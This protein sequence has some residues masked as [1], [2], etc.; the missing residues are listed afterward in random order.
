MPGP[1]PKALI[2]RALAIEPSQKTL[3]GRLGMKRAHLNRVI[4]GARLGE[5]NC[6]RLAGLLGE[7]PSVVLQAWRYD[8]LAQICA[9][10]ETPP[11]FTRMQAEIADRA[12]HLPTA[13]QRAIAGLLRALDSS[14]E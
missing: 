8:D 1:T 14:A 6:I 12:G 10:S 2:D 13:Q 11:K 3:A 5:A 4:N 9:R 7:S